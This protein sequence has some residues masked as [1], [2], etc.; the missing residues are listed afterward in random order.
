M[1]PTTTNVIY[2][3]EEAMGNAKSA[4]DRAMKALVTHLV[5]FIMGIACGYAWF[6]LQ[7]D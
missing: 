4:E 1:S 6:F 5:I 2:V 3:N 7:G